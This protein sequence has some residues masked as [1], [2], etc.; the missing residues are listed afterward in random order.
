VERARPTPPGPDRVVPLAL[1]PRRG[2]PLTPLFSELRSLSRSLFAVGGRPP[3][4]PECALRARVACCAR[5]AGLRSEGA[6]TSPAAGLLLRVFRTVLGL[7][8][9]VLAA[10]RDGRAVRACSTRPGRGG[11]RR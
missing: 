10:T 3:T 7:L 4:A 9:L 11:T 6:G 5:C 2:G 1:P 8:R